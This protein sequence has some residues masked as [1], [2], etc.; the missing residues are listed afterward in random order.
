MAG[1]ST[2][3]GK[4]DKSNAKDRSH[5]A[6]KYKGVASIG[7]IEPLKSYKDTEL[8]S[9]AKPGMPEM[10]ISPEPKAGPGWKMQNAPAK[11]GDTK[12]PTAVELTKT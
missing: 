5:T 2:W 1:D 3:Q 10:S 8:A 9:P 11:L 6:K 7:L 4:A 12:R